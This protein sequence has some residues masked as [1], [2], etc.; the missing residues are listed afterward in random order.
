MATKKELTSEELVKLLIK[1]VVSNFGIPE[2]IISDNDVRITADF[3]GK[4]WKG[5]GTKS[6]TSTPRYQQAN[7][8][9]E[10]TVHM[11]RKQEAIGTK[12]CVW[13]SSLLILKHKSRLKQ[14]HLK[15]C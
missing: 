7:G 13:L 6:V 15:Q 9:A 11:L 2:V 5:L 10:R 8:Q 1:N 14:L 12:T 4:F 3:G